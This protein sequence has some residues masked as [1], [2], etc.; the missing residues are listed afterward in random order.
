MGSV[1]RSRLNRRRTRCQSSEGRT[2]CRDGVFRMTLTAYRV[3]GYTRSPYF[4]RGTLF[5]MKGSLAMSTR[6]TL[7][8][9]LNIIYFEKLTISEPS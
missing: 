6:L 1:G 7:I 2:V 9:F 8:S 5:R 3:P 4:Q